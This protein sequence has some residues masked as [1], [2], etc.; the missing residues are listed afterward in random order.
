[1]L[2]AS[3]VHASPVPQPAAPAVNQIVWGIW[4]LALL[5]PLSYQPAWRGTPL[6]Y[7]ADIWLCL[8]VLLEWFSDRNRTLAHAFLSR[9]IGILPFVLVVSL[10]SLRG[11]LYLKEAVRWTEFMMVT[12][13][14]YRIAHRSEKPLAILQGILLPAVGVSLWG[15]A[16]FL[17]GYQIAERPGAGAFFLHPNPYGAYLSL[18][19]LPCIGLALHATHQQ[20][21]RF[22]GLASVA[23]LAGIVTSLS[24]GTWLACAAGCL[25][26][27][28]LYLR[29]TRRRGGAQVA[30]I[31]TVLAVLGGLFSWNKAVRISRGGFSTAYHQRKD[32]LR[33]APALLITAEKQSKTQE[34]N[35]EYPPRFTRALFGLGAHTVHQLPTRDFHSLYL[36]IW[37][38][39][40]LVGLGCFLFMIYRLTAPLFATKILDSSPA[41]PV[42]LGLAGSQ[43]CYLVNGLTG[44]FVVHGI[45]IQWAMMLGMAHSLVQGRPR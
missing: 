22:W 14:V 34:G 11:S 1:M 44:F 24:R 31:L 26:F 8:L 29:C 28:I 18:S 9:W 19:L 10:D 12:H 43:I 41:W 42:F 17:S 35:W 4:G 23:L 45:Q 21:L 20:S 39:F 40:G 25:W 2:T 36:Q 15:L 30:F 32:Y 7:A 16:H 13:L 6:Y 27:G 33:L 5:V 3:A 38:S 37:V